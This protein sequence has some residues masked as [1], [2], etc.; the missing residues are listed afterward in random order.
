MLRGYAQ[1]ALEDVALWHER[2][3]SHSGAERVILPDATIA[4]DYMQH[5]TLRV[6]GGM[7]VHR[8]RMLAN[9]ELTCGA[10][11]SQR[12][13]LAL[14]AGGMARDDA[15]RTVQRLAQRAWDTQT[16]LRSLLEAEPGMELDLDAIF[17]Y[18]HYMRHVPEVLARLEEIP[19]E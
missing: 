12:V 9:L 13:L 17:D 18:G 19:R 16:S 10:L 7:T 8:D 11:F 14:V 5:L 3:I 1:A 15:Y 4:L 6:V 2:D